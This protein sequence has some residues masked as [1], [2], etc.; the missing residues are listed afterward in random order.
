MPVLLK[1]PEG[2][3]IEAPD[4]EVA[5]L[6]RRGYTPESAEQGATRVADQAREAYYTTP[7]A[8]ITTALAGIGRTV[9]GGGTDALASLDPSLG[10][11]FAALRE[12]NAPLST[13]SEVAGAFLPIGVAGAA[14]RAGAAVGR[15]GEGASALTKIGRAAG[16]AAV[17]GAIL[18]AGSGVSEVALSKDPISLERIVSTVGSS[19][20]FGGGVGGAIGG[21]T[22]AAG[23]GLRGVQSKL[24]DIATRGA[25]TEVDDAAKI[26]LRDEVGAFRK[27]LKA[28]QPWIAAKDSGIDGLR[29]V[30]KRSFKAD[31]A[32]DNLLDDPKALID[33][34]KAALRHLRIQESALQDIAN[35][36]DDLRASLTAQQSTRRM[37][38]LDKVAPTLE[39]NRTLQQKIESI[40][41]KPVAE[42][43]GGIGANMLGGQAF[44]LGASIVGAIPVVGPLLAPLAGAAA[45]KAV[46]DGLG[47]MATK[48]AARASKAIGSFLNVAEKVPNVAPVLASKVLTSVKFGEG[49]TPKSDETK[50]GKPAPRIAAAYKARTTEIKQLTQYGL[51]GKAQMRPEARQRMA[52]TFDAVRQVDPVAAD[53]METLAARRITALADRIPR[54]PDVM[55]TNVGGPDKW[56]P[57]EMQMRGY[58]RFVAA[59]ED[60]IGVVE[61]LATGQITPEDKDAMK[62][63]YPELYANVQQ[64]IMAQ[65]PTLQK[66]L[67]Y[68]R[69][70]ALSIFSGLPVDPAMTP[71][72]LNV[73]QA[74]FKDEPG[75]EGGT[76]A[77]TPQPAFGSVKNQ[78]AT[79]SQQREM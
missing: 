34:P 3:T 28:D 7:A 60:P 74:S 14:S 11:D 64:Q 49:K 46:T 77:P 24:D 72:I 70:I 59:V 5:Y 66:S 17:E 20:M 51:D 29:D 78:E 38:A 58:A 4:D 18:G 1:S 2:E 47:K 79:P 53:Q 76:Q 31:K 73:L 30:G 6:T 12:Y 15:V 25:V 45:S 71:R 26:A 52:T 22:K 35:K 42:K 21:L 54:K 32:L 57:S 65:L 27:Q 8:K 37:A 19:A 75:T 62:T 68:Q 13:V 36:T 23:I 39:A 43:A 10:E 41:A 69:R 61:R 9:T 33:N 63:V 48:Q 67:P 16:G 56:Q 44:G 40:I 55:G 50:P